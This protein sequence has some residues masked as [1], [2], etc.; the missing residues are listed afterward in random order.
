[1]RKI[2]KKGGGGNGLFLE[3][4]GPSSPRLASGSPGPPNDF[5]VK[6]PARLG[7][8]VTSRLRKENLREKRKKRKRSQYATES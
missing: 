4:P 8:P 2:P 1:M 6:E 7:E 3:F 5:R